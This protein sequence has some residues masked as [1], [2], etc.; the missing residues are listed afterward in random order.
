M[1]ARRSTATDPFEEMFGRGDEARAG[2]GL[3]ATSPSLWPVSA[4]RWAA[5]V[6]AVTAFEARWGGLAR[7]GGWTNLAIY[8]LGR[9]APYADLSRMGAAWLAARNDRTVIGIDAGSIM[10]VTRTAAR[11]RIFRGEPNGGAVLVW[12]LVALK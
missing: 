3:L 1:M 6:A 8:G 11:L 4:D 7:M 10:L 12:E 2:L 9:T 5:T